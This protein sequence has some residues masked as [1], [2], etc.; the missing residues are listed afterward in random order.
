MPNWTSNYLTISGN[1]KQINKFLKEVERTQIEAEGNSHFEAS[2]F[3]FNRIIPMPDEL[4]N[5]GDSW[6]NWRV[7]NWNTKWEARIDYD[8]FDEWESGEVKIEFSTAWSAP[9]QIIKKVV[10]SYPKLY[11]HFTCWEES[12]EF[13]AEYHGRTG[14]LIEV[15][16]GEFRGCDDYRQFGL[17]H[18]S[19]YR[20]EN[21]VECGDIVE[22]GD[23]H[24]ICW[25]CKEQEIETDKEVSKLD[26]QLWEGE[27]ESGREALSN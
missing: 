26:E 21:Y 17:S 5:Q 2:K 19:C 18:H 7:S 23:E 16:D 6:Y 3:A 11:F 27:I 13:W 4:F 8:T 22:I 12:Y 1:P 15:Y 20:C 25:S 24:Q 9:M 14:K 10:E